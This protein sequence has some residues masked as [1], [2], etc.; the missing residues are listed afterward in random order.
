MTT[1]I[2][3]GFDKDQLQSVIAAIR[4]NA[5]TGKTVWRAKTRSLGGFRSQAEIGGHVVPMDE[6]SDLGGSSTAPNMVEMVLGAYG[7][8]LNTG[9]VAQAALRG[10]ELEDVQIEL[11]GDLDLRSFLGLADPDRVWPGYTQVRTKVHLK[12]PKATPE[13]LRE[14]HEAVVRTSPVGSILERPIQVTTELVVDD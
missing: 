10:I 5:E 2:T 14:L 6:P 13:Q 8:C 7:C 1:N 12:A 9:Y 11:E 3:V 4:E